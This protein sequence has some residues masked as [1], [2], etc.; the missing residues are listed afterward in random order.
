MKVEPVLAK[1]NEL[2]KDTQGE[3]GIEEKA[4]YHG[5][6]FISY[7]IGA[8]TEFVERDVPPSGKKETAA[9]EGARSL[10]DALE[11]L[12]EDAAGDEE[13]MEFVVLD[14]AVAF[15]SALPG[16][17]QHYLNEAGREAS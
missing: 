13:D 17:F 8:F 4:L 15:I 14:K 11:E 6:C 5:F 12:R 16:D 1:L 9:G 10:I 7:E 3:G 2:R